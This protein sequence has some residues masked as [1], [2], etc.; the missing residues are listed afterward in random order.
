MTTYNVEDLKNGLRS[1]E[2][3]IHALEAAIEAQKKKR[4]EYLEHISRALKILDQHGVDADGR[5]K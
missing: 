4:D 1:V 2:D 3:N 5:T